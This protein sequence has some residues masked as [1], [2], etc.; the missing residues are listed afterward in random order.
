MGK[1][2][3]LKRQLHNGTGKN[4]IGRMPIRTLEELQNGGKGTYKQNP[5]YLQSLYN[6]LRHKSIFG[7]S[8]KPDDRSLEEVVNSYVSIVFDM[9]EGQEVIDSEEKIK[10]KDTIDFSNVI[11][12]GLRGDSGD[13]P[14]VQIKKEN[15][16]MANQNFY[17]AIPP[18][19]EGV[20]RVNKERYL[21]FKILE[22]DEEEKSV[23]C[24]IRDYSNDKTWMLEN[25]L[26]EA[27][28]Y[29]STENGKPKLKLAEKGIQMADFILAAIH[30]QKIWTEADIRIIEEVVVPFVK[31]YELEDELSAIC[32]KFYQAIVE[33]NSQLM[34]GKPKPQRKRKGAKVKVVYG[35]AEK[36]PKPQI[37]RTLAGGITIKSEKIPRV[38]TEEII[39]HYKVA[40]WNTRGHMRTYKNGK[41]VYVRPSVHHRKCMEKGGEKAPQTI[42]QVRAMEG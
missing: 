31:L 24:E 26:K 35:E 27:K 29:I 1:L 8:G 25:Y 10:Q 22:I 32:T 37:I 33:T 42:I 16:E 17:M 41:T 6:K 20:L 12:K 7:K 14:S 18:L 4:E 30:G 36:N 21:E 40:V 2:R 28:A 13:F 11:E 23:T 19:K 39:R 3:K 9:L 34:Q 15:V 38:P 5:V